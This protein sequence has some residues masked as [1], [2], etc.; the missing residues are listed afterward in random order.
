MYFVLLQEG[1]ADFSGINHIKNL[2]L[3]DVVQLTEFQS[4]QIDDAPPAYPSRSRRKRAA[5][6]NKEEIFYHP[7]YIYGLP[8][9]EY[10]QKDKVKLTR[11]EP[12]E[13]NSKRE[14]S[15]LYPMEAFGIKINPPKSE[16]NRESWTTNL[17]KEDSERESW[18]PTARRTDVAD[19]ISVP[20]TDKPQLSEA[21]PPTSE[22]IETKSVQPSSN[23]VEKTVVPAVVTEAQN[24]NP[25]PTYYDYYNYQDYDYASDYLGGGAHHQHGSF[26]DRIDVADYN[27]HFGEIVEAHKDD[28]SFPADRMGPPNY[29]NYPGETVLAAEDAMYPEEA[30]VMSGNGNY[31]QDGMGMADDESMY[32]GEVIGTRHYDSIPEEKMTPPV[33]THPINRMGVAGGESSE[34]IAP[35]GTYFRQSDMGTLAFDRAFFYAVRH[36][37]TGLLLFLGRYLDPEGN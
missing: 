22:Y 27:T 13:N 4:C 26:G 10:L 35:P 25:A 11:M 37:P 5:D 1:E 3:S 2:H 15:S 17:Q 23:S 20:L 32:P 7:T 34:Y 8:M 6:D 18:D 16:A 31:P 30:M 14:T 36:N 19:H 12:G 24:E 21:P 9:M 28:N 29:N 33:D